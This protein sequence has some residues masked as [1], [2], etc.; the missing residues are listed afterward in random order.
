MAEGTRLT[1]AVKA[2]EER[3]EVFAKE[4][5]ETRVTVMAMS[6]EMQVMNDRLTDFMV[7]FNC[8][9]AEL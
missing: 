2:N 7:S 8:I 9:A 1:Q 4:S 5:A 6:K 3:I